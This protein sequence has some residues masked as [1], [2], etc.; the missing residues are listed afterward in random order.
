MTPEAAQRVAAS[1]SKASVSSRRASASIPTASL[2]AHLLGW[3]GL[4]NVGLGGIESTYDAEIRGKN[5]R[6][7]IQTDARRRAFSRDER[8]PTAGSTV[9]LTIDEYLQHIAEREL[10]AGVLE[11]RALGG[12]ARSS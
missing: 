8:L 4:D 1:T 5:G 3:V 11:N 7:L 2:A 10:H 12:I 9:E 6:V